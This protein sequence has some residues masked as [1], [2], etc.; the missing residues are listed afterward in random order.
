MA[1][2]NNN[3][4]HPGD[5]ATRLRNRGIDTLSPYCSPGRLCA[6]RAILA[7]NLLQ[8][9]EGV[10]KAPA[11]KLTNVGDMPVSARVSRLD[12][13]KWKLYRRPNEE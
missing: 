11:K 9:D 4:S 8:R 5:A 3:S 13:R 1:G 2:D 7:R 10:R 6:R 12:K